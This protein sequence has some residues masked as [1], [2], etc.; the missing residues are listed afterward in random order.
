MEKDKL[1]L[2]VSNQFNLNNNE[3]NI[4]LNLSQGALITSGSVSGTVY[5]TTLL[6]GKVV[7]NATVKVFTAE[8]VPYAHT[9]T[10]DAGKYTIGN[11]PIG[12]YL[13]AATKD[14]YI[15]SEDLPLTITN[16]IPVNINLVIT[17][18]KEINKNIIY[19]KLIDNITKLSLEG[20]E[21]QLYKEVA[22]IQTLVTSTTS[23]SDGEYILDNI[24]DGDYKISYV[25][26]GYQLLEMNVTLASGIKFLANQSLNS[27]VGKINNTV[28]GVIKDNLGNLVR[29]ALVAL[30]QIVDGKEILVATTYTNSLGKYM[31]GNIND[32][33][34]LVKSKFSR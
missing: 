22:G 34:Y 12:V 15:L 18:N 28:S 7:N 21:V 29:N 20:V 11:L 13:I 8:G 17:P 33:E 19:G 2:N 10:N 14:G 9:L 26:T 4:D 23:I 24:D 1:K 3:E 32:G 16:T 27:S 31:F 6:T 5:D 25:K 30:Y